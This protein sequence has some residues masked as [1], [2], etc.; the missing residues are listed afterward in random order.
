MNYKNGRQSISKNNKFCALNY[1]EVFISLGLSIFIL[2]SMPVK[3]AVFNDNSGMLYVFGVLT[4]SACR[5]D[6]SSVHQDIDLGAIATGSLQ[7]VG[8]R[9]KPVSVELYLLDCLPS[10]ASSDD[11]HNGG[12]LW[13]ENQPAV[14]V[15]FNA[16]HDADN[17]DLVK[18]QGVSGLGLRI[19]DAQGRDVRL[20]S[21]AVSL[22]LTPGNNMLTYHITPERTAAP[23]NPGI[24]HAVINFNLS[25][26]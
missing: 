10:P 23:L 4:E 17:P 13:A 1:Y 2:F 7:V 18:A 6:M 5:L 21:N 20:D 9:G 24:Y 22:L 25:Y 19:E 14:T 15:K 11:M 12:I 26:D 16:I 8:A 3:A